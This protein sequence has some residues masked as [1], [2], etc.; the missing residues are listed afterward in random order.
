MQL[1]LYDALSAYPAYRSLAHTYVGADE[2][3][4]LLQPDEG[5]LKLV[6]LGDDMFAVYLSRERST[7]WQVGASAAEVAEMVATLRDSIALT[8]GGTTATY[9]FDVDTSRHL[10]DALFGPVAG[11]LAPARPPGV[12]A[13]RRAAAAAGQPAGDRPG[14]RRRL[15]PAGRRRRRRVRLPRRRLARPRQGDQHRAVAGELPRRTQRAALGCGQ[16]LHRPR[17]ER[18]GRPCHPAPRWC[19]VRRQRPTAGCE[20]PLASWNRPVAADELVLASQVFGP[21]RSDVVTGRRV[22]RHRGRGP[23]RPRVVSASSIRHAWP[24][25]P[26]ARRLPG[27]TRAADQLRRGRLGRAAAVSPKCSSSSSTPTW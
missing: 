6:R 24:R 13:R 17:A 4:A 10:F 16:G 26:A 19:A 5:Y 23:R 7:A 9:P 22:H 18:A 12:R 21:A 15:S 2:L 25:H 27:A 20:V 14:G 11:D 8:I 3:T 1:E